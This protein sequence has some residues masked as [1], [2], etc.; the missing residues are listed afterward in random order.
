MMNLPTLSQCQRWQRKVLFASFFVLS[1]LVLNTLQLANASPASA[2]LPDVG[3]RDFSYDAVAGGV[4]SPTGEKPES[5]LWW[6]DGIWWASM[7][8]LTA[9]EYHIHRFDPSTN[10]WTDTGTLLDNRNHTKADLLWDGTKLYVASHPFA[11]PPVPSTK[12]AE[13]KR[14]TYDSTTKTYTLDA[15]FPVEITGA[16]TETLTLAKDSTGRLWVTWVEPDNLDPALAKYQVKINHSKGS[17]PS[18]TSWDIDTTPKVLPFASAQDV[19][20]DDI[21]GVISFDGN[22]IGVMWSNQKDATPGFNFAV[23]VDTDPD[24]TWSG[25]SVYSGPTTANDHLN[26]KSLQG[27][28]AGKI[29]ASIKTS[30]TVGT[31]PGIVLLVCN[32]SPCSSAGN[33]TAKT[34]AKHS[35]DWTRPITLINTST[36]TLYVFAG[37]TEGGGSIQ[38]KSTS[39]DNIDFTGYGVPFIQLATDPA[40]NDPT[41][42][43]QNVTDAMGILVL[44][45]DSSTRYYMHN[46]LGIPF[47][48]SISTQ[49][50]NQTVTDGQTASFTAAASGNPT[51][52]V[53]WQRSTDGGSTWSDISG[54]TSPT[55]SFTA[56]FA[57]NGYKYRAVFTNSLGST[58]TNA[59]TL[60]VQTV[61]VITSAN[62]VTFTVGRASTFL[63]TTTG[64]P[65]PSLSRTGILPAGV[66]FVDNGNGTATLSG[67]PMSGTGG[68][69]PLTI[70]ASNGIGTNA[71]QNFT[72]TVLSR[73]YLPLIRRQ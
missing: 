45:S 60:T 73:V 13:L 15:G 25:G 61:P 50:T 16:Q 57:Q 54:A 7:F 39:L 6:N 34:V 33:W 5:K 67:T 37:V 35:E 12:H 70:T 69:Y 11:R 48:P 3:Y 29:F 72:L 22:K 62:Q 32:T 41:S 30:N 42:T 21:A 19:A 20:P 24:T 2:L 59:A 28:S 49:P 71:T 31:D 46:G 38:Y 9:Q 64:N 10:V 27:D 18:D 40:I 14:Y 55:Y 43:K 26:L 63:V 58:P 51:P 52:T 53:Q 8:D 23:H 65:A 4:A 66:T 44:A 68:V 17:T 56:A 36:R 47:A 1:I